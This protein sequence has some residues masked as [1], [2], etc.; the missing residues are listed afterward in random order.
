MLPSKRLKVYN[1]VKPL[2]GNAWFT[3][4][5]R[6]SRDPAKV[7]LGP[8]Y[9]NLFFVATLHGLSC[10]GHVNRPKHISLTRFMNHGLT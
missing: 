10:L 9:F 7:E 8:C 2:F 6:R 4:T 3:A 1:L 5:A